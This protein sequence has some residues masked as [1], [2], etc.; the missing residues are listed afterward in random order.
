MEVNAID[1][2]MK[3]WDYKETSKVSTW[4][5]RAVM[6]GSNEH[7]IDVQLAGDVDY[8]VKAEAKW[9][10]GGSDGPKGSVGVGGSVSDGNGNSASASVQHDSNGKTSA[11]ASVEH[12]SKSSDK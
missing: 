9:E 12:E 11:S 4:N 3:D 6:L 7:K 1:A 8:S 2:D 5:G 10:W